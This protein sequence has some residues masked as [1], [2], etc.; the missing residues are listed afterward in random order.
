VRLLF[1]SSLKIL[2]FVRFVLSLARSLAA[3]AHRSLSLSRLFPFRQSNQTPQSVTQDPLD[4]FCD[5]NPDADECRIY[6]D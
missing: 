2:L 1:C 4:K 3:L 5:D 6:D